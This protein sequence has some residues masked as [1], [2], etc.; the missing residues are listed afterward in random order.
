MIQINAYA[1]KYRE[2]LIRALVVMVASYACFVIVGCSSGAYIISSHPLN[3]VLYGAQMGGLLVGSP[4]KRKNV[5][6]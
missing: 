6:N 3:S 5:V 4:E 2:I 1:V